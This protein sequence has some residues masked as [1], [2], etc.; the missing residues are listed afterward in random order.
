MV[1]TIAS[2]SGAQRISPQSDRVGVLERFRRSV[3]RIGHVGM[4]A[5]DA[6]TVGTRPHAAS[7][8][9]VVSEGVAGARIDAADGEII[10]GSGCGCRDMVG[11]RL[12]QS[13]QQY[14]H[15]ALR[16]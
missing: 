6:V 7:D 5:G 13:S 8:G 15:Y 12:G 4:D 14:V 11:N 3:E 10:H 9:F 2:T 16:R 1:E